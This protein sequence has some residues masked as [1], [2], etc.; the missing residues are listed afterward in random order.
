MNFKNQFFMKILLHKILLQLELFKPLFPISR[1]IKYLQNQNL[2]NRIK[3][4]FYILFVTG[5][6]TVNGQ[7]NCPVTIHSSY[8]K[9]N[10]TPNSAPT[11]LWLNI[12]TKLNKNQLTENGDYVMFTGGTL[13]FRGINTS[14]G[15]SISL[16]N[17]QIIA[18][19]SVSTPFTSFNSSTNTWVTRVPLS[20]SS[21]DLFL[22][23]AAIISTTGFG[24]QFGGEATILSGNFYSNKSFSS[25]WFYGISCYQP[26]FTNNTVGDVNADNGIPLKGLKTG[27]PSGQM[28]IATI[29][30][31]LLVL[32]PLRQ[33]LFFQ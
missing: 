27:T 15:A 4:L 33:H 21:T 23:G 10:S 14:F 12:H 7:Q 32:T 1:L 9:F 25:S 20:Y 24:D 13:S 3:L 22:S 5:A 18:D 11:T 2:T 31:F 28:G 29:I 26:T 17:G 30:I 19:N 16:P 6:A 8:N